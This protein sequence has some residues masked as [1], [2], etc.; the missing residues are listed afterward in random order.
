L[1]GRISLTGRPISFP[2]YEGTEVQAPPLLGQHTDSVLQELLGC[3][4][5]RLAGLRA[6][7]V[8]A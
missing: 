8:I 6:D 3:D 4:E 7:G 5:K 2:A 1:L